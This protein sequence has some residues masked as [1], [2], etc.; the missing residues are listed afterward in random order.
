MQSDGNIYTREDTAKKVQRK[1]GKQKQILY[2][3]KPTLTFQFWALDDGGLFYSK[4]LIGKSKH[5]HS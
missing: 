1:V 5:S 4:C 2:E 3:E